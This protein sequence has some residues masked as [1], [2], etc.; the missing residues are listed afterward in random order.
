MYLSKPI[1]RILLNIFNIFNPTFNSDN[2]TSAI[3]EDVSAR[4]FT[5]F[6]VTF[7]SQNLVS[8]IDISNIDSRNEVLI[9]TRLG[10]YESIS[11]VLYL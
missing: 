6:S 1:K 2:V 7:R 9:L 5:L 11:V 3:A 10:I 4:D 8:Y